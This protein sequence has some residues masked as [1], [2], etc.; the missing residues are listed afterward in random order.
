MEESIQWIIASTRE[1]RISLVFTTNPEILVKA[2][3]ETSLVEILKKAHLSLPDGTGILL[4]A[5]Y[6][7]YVQKERVTG[8]DL[9]QRLL[10]IGSQE[11]ISFYFLGGRVGVAREAAKRMKTL[12]PQLTVLG[13]HHGYL[14]DREEEVLSEINSLKPHILLVGMGAPRQEF[15]LYRHRERL[16]IN[17]GITVGGSFDVLSG[18]LKRAPN[19][20]ISLHLEWLYRLIQEPSRWRRM[21][22][23]PYFLYLVWR[24]GERRR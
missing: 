18:T 24:E 2:K 23:L 11:G 1:E 19:W 22:S 5:K 21:F 15:F 9:V 7:G 16:D 12:Y 3:K 17:V 8:I 4:A 13:S 20:L 10:E 6:L 14:E